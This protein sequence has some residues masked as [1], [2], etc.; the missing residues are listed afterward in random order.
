VVILHTG[1]LVPADARLLEAINL[2]AEEAAL[3]GESV[4]VEKHVRPLGEL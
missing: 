1:D 4:P 2:Q 3:T